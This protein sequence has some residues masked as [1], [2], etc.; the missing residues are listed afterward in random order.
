M[1]DRAGSIVGSST[2]KARIDYRKVLKSFRASIICD[3]RK[4]TRLRPSRRFDFECMGS[5]YD[6]CTKLLLAVDT[7]GSISN[8]ELE[9]F[10]V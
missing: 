8:R 1:Y 5:N 10:F 3:K 2:K 6:F 9:N 4:L 7:S